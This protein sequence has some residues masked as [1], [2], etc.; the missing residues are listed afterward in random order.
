MLNPSTQDSSATAL[1]LLRS[2]RRFLLVGHVR[3]DGDVLGSQAALKSVLE[4]IGKKV[5][6]LNPDAPQPQFDYLGGPETFGVYP[7]G[8]LP[9][10][11][12]ACL[13]D[14]CDVSRCGALAEPLVRAR[15]KKLVV[16]HHLHD[17]EP[18]WDACYVDQEAAATG[19]LVR[20]LARDLGSTLDLRA[21]LGIFTSLVADTGWFKYSNTD[22]EAFAVASEMVS[23]GV[24][25][26][27]VFAA[28][29][30]RAAP[31][32]PRA[33]AR[34]LNALEYEAEGRLALVALPRPQG[35]EP[36][37]ADGDEALDILRSVDRVEVVLFL[38]ELPDGR[39]KLS[40]RSKGD[41]DVNALSRRFGGGGHR[42][43]SG[44]TL[45]GPLAQARAK[46][47]DA[48]VEQLERG[49]RAER[50]T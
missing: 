27:R 13:L 23:L 2:S 39:V 7:G 12:V 6:I 31:E 11:E 49:E 29:H 24:E 20:R 48:A 37:L 1:D 28:L 44:A 17:G 18:W 45:A 47:L 42:K 46:L 26:N 15:S 40:A 50:E 36:D 43:A 41:F 38:R 3:P 33:L 25:P 4:S 21:A 35:G 32:Q 8:E 14:F 22:V 16:D 34:A 10:H 9:A 5:V 19:L 30:Q